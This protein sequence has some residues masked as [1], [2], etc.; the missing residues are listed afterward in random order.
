MTKIGRAA[1]FID[2]PCNMT[3]VTATLL[4]L[5][6]HTITQSERAQNLAAAQ[7]SKHETYHHEACLCKSC[8]T[9]RISS[10]PQADEQGAR[11]A[12]AVQHRNDREVHDLWRD[13]V[14]YAA[15]SRLK[16]HWLALCTYSCSH[17]LNPPQEISSVTHAQSMSW[18]KDE[19]CARSVQE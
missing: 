6:S 1:L 8:G 3:V 9:R 11:Q 19:P 10:S 17:L 13:S 14:R 2:L 15:A 16:Q 7:A 18:A 4:L 12:T 5:S